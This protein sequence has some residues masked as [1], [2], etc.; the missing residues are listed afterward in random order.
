MP[1]TREEGK[2]KKGHLPSPLFLCG[3]PTTK[4]KF[5]HIPQRSEV[6]GEILLLVGDELIK[7]LKKGLGFFTPFN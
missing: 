6:Y 2:R 7:K 3:L 4:V 5:C 1:L